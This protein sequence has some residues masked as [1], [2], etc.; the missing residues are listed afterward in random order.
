M[1]TILDFIARAKEFGLFEF[2]L[3]F[4]L[5][6]ALFYGLLMK[7]KVFGT[8][9]VARNINA[10]ISFAAAF[11][12]MGYTPVGAA[13]GL[14]ISRFLGT[15]AAVIIMVLA[16]L[17]IVVLFAPE[18]EKKFPGYLK[19]VAPVAAIIVI[20]LA[21]WYV[22]AF[23]PE[24]AVPTLPAIPLSVEDIVIVVFLIGIII[25]IWLLIKGEGAP[26]PKVKYV[27]PAEFI[28]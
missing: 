18:P 9:R 20:G 10:I 7:S 6:F 5:I 17:M 14:F 15:A 28:S 11:L 25:V 23:F 16:F 1:V 19:Y 2:Y 13:L 3:P 4:V 8:E 24:I 12:I 22:R 21:L 26:A 27:I